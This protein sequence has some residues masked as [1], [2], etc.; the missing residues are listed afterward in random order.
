[1]AKTSRERDYEARQAKLEHVREQVESG[2]LVIR[3]MTKAERV[4]WAK[5]SAAS[6]ARSTPAELSSRAAALESRRKR[7]A[8]FSVNFGI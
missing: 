6:E 2:E 4:R 8:R 7:A 5:R 3:E 1:V